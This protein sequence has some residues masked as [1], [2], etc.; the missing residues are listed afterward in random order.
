MAEPKKLPNGRWQV[1]YRDPEGRPRSKVCDTKAE[2]R[3][4]VQDVGHAGRT[5]GWVAPEL[6]RITLRKPPA[7]RTVTCATRRTNVCEPLLT[8]RQMERWHKDRKAHNSGTKARP[9]ARP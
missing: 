1:R 9:W 2:A 8:Y 7:V 6:G 3:D 5:K 4:Y